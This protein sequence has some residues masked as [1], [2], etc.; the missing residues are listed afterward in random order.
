L[1]KLAGRRYNIGVK[2]KTTKRIYA[3]LG[4]LGVLVGVGYI[5]QRHYFFGAIYMLFGVIWL[6]RSRKNT[7][8][9]TAVQPA[10]MSFGSPAHS[11]G[12]PAT[13]AKNVSRL[14]QS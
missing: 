8:E 4:L 5:F 1:P 7:P 10:E 11:T 14:S 13:E 3:F 12:L 6:L 2:S 9:E